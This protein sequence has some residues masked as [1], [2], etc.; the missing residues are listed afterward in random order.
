MYKLCRD[1]MYVG[2]KKIIVKE[3]KLLPCFNRRQEIKM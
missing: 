1:Y 3:L 2:F